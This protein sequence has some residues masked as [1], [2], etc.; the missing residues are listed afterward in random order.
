MK[1]RLLLSTL[2]GASFVAHADGFDAVANVVS[3]TA[4]T[5]QGSQQYASQQDCGNSQ[6]QQQTSQGGGL[7]TGGL[8][9]GVVGA[10][11]GS[12]MGKG[13]GKNVATAAGAAIGYATGDTVAN[14]SAPTEN[15][16]GRVAGGV[17]GG[18]V[19]SQV[20]GGSGNI[21]ATGVGAI[22]GVAA[23]DAISN[24]NQQPTYQNGDCSNQY[25][26][27]VIG[28]DVQYE[29]GGRVFTTRM[30]RQV[31]NTIPVYVTVL[32]RTQ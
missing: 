24:R 6:Q 9:G 20:G 10:L 2:L 3:Q 4:V 17:V 22:G 14:G 11:A 32:P 15:V 30:S 16:L 26:N 12:Q 21:A 8:I 18:L 19:G 25:S 27:Q 28:Y 31:G 13:K 29:Y 1:S 7:N 5:Q 23:A